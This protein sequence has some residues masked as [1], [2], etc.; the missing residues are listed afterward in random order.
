MGVEK[1]VC[2]LFR[3]ASIIAPVV[4]THRMDVQFIT[5]DKRHVVFLHLQRSFEDLENAGFV[6]LDY[7]MFNGG[8]ERGQREW[9]RLQKG[10]IVAQLVSKFRILLKALTLG[11]AS[12][13]SH[14]QA[15]AHDVVIIAQFA[16]FVE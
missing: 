3:A 15:I 13:E 7:V 10:V 12:M 6:V 1:G 8:L 4:R 9:E 11:G 5:V 14:H 16:H 2:M